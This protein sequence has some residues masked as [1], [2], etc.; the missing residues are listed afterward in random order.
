MAH[1]RRRVDHNC[2]AGSQFNYFCDDR[3]LDLRGW[4]NRND[5]ASANGWT[6]ELTRNGEDID[7]AGNKLVRSYGGT[8]E[9]ALRDGLRR[10][11]EEPCIRPN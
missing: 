4:D 3:S 6:R 8:E 7:S 10:F 9:N 5:V 1:N 11:D 2:H